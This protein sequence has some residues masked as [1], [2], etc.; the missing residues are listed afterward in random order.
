MAAAKGTT[1]F[2]IRANVLF[3]TVNKVVKV[4]AVLLAI[5]ATL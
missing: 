2:A 3:Q 1:W 4:A 5:S